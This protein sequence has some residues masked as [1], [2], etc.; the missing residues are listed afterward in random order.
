[1]AQAFLVFLKVMAYLAANRPELVGLVKN[2]QDLIPD[3]PGTSKAGAV[4]EF[5]AKVLGVE[6]HIDQAWPLVAPFFNLFVAGVKGKPSAET[7][8]AA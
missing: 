1:M 5:V 3:A 4:K 6:E 8:P 2:V 7:P